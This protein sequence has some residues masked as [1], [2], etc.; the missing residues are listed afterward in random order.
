MKKCILQNQSL[1]YCIINLNVT[2]SIHHQKILQLLPEKIYNRWQFHS[3]G[4][5]YYFFVCWFF[6]NLNTWYHLEC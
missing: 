6:T 1:M 2:F 3:I 4:M 5:Y